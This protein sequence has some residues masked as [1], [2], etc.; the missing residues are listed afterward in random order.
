M[1]KR[2]TTGS[3]VCFSCQKLVSIDQEK[4]PFC[5]QPHPGLW[6]YARPIRRL[7]ADFGFIKIV[8]VGCIILY[9]IT[10]LFDLPGVRSQ[11]VMRL[12]APSSYSL[13]IF[14]S[15][16]SIPL[17]E[18]GR[19][20]TVIG[21]GWL[22]G[23]LWHLCF[24]LVWLSFLSPMVAGGYGAGRLVSIYTVTTVTSSLVTSFV[25]QYWPSLPASFSG[26]SFSVGASGGVFGLLGALVIYGQ[27][28]GRQQVLQQA[29]ILSI[30][31]FV[32][33]AFL[34]RVDNWGHLG[35][36]IGGYLIGLMPGFNPNQPQRLYHLGIAVGALGVTLICVILSPIHGLLF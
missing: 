4:C 33:S 18:W 22:H 27:R 9:A 30:V 8:S 17:F 14:G 34:G 6:G 10:L 31:S 24:N 7:G 12:L 1:P 13:A 23:D 35:G 11:G 5:G 20:W 36:F 3:V 32:L 19:W 25:A 15:T 29:L 28:S 26:A 2:Q 16:G 21:S